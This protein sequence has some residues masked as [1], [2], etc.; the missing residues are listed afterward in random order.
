MLPCFGK[1]WDISCTHTNV[2]QIR[3]HSL[4]QELE[5]L[6]T[7]LPMYFKK[8]LL[9][10]DGRRIRI[11]RRRHY[12]TSSRRGRSRRINLLGSTSLDAENPGLWETGPRSRILSC[13]TRFF[14]H[15]VE[16]CHS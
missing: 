12:V 6:S 15:S 11:E 3:E 9:Q 8:Q 1:S 13:K 10:I 2:G 4:F 7:Q 16:T 5:T 14:K